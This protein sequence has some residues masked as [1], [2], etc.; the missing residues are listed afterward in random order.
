MPAG[1]AAG[2]LFRSLSVQPPSGRETP[3]GLGKRVSAWSWASWLALGDVRLVPWLEWCLNYE[4][5]LKERS[6]AST[7]NLPNIL[8]VPIKKTI[9]IWT[10]L[11]NLFENANNLF[12][13]KVAK[14]FN[15]FKLGQVKPITQVWG[16]WTYAGGSCSLL[17]ADE[18][19]EPKLVS[20]NTVKRSRITLTTLGNGEERRRDLFS[21]KVLTFR[22]N[23]SWLV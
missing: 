6:F 20:V 19:V 4:V 5:C 9:A 2:Q 1:C 12:A 17:H 10:G 18:I 14:Y 3:K 15:P 22:S 11:Y 16:S 13:W 23:Y 7:Q 21:L 8:L